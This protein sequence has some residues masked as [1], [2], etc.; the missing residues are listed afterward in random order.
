MKKISKLI[1]LF[2]LLALIVMAPNTIF[3]NSESIILKKSGE[4][5]IYNTEAMNDEFTFAFGKENKKDDLIFFQSAKDSNTSD[6]KNVAYV[7]ETTKAYFNENSEAFLNNAINKDIVDTTTKRIS[8]DTTQSNTTETTID[9]VRTE[10]TKGKIVI[11]DSETAK[12]SYILIK[13]PT[14]DE[15]N[16]SKLMNSAEKLSNTADL[17]KIN[18]IQKLNLMKE[19]YSLYM[20]LQPKAD[21]ESWQEVQNSQIL[22]PED[23]KDGEKYIVFIKSVDG[24]TTKIDVQFLTSYTEYNQLYE[25]ETITI[26]E[27]SKLP[28]TYD[29]NITL[30]IFFAIIIVA[31]VVVLVIR[32]KVS[33]KKENE[34]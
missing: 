12:Y 4:Y 7:D 5:L 26:K 32:E 1:L 23:S 16:Y 27:T 17:Q 19:F 20:N 14:E 2:G 28:V 24:N 29:E 31:I 10:V 18:F 6:A 3:A 22:Q 30:I 11:T 33:N 21:D 15:N 8:V 25:K 13:L 9:G 34:Q